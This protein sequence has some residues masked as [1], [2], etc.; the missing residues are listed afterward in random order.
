LL[1]SGQAVEEPADVEREEPVHEGEEPVLAG[2]APEEQ[3]PMAAVL[4]P[5]Y[6]VSA[7]WTAWVFF[8][9]FFSSLVPEAPR[10]IAN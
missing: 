4:V 3:G 9:S 10:G 6:R 8:K 2:A 1:F 7:V 5:P